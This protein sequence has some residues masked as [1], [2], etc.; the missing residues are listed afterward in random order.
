MT[1]RNSS[2][3]ICQL[4]LSHPKNIRERFFSAMLVE[5]DNGRKTLIT[6]HLAAAWVFEYKTDPAEDAVH[7]LLQGI[8]DDKAYLKQLGIKGLYSVDYTTGEDVFSTWDEYEARLKAKI[9]AEE[10]GEQ[11]FPDGSE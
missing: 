6:V 9:A 7:A 11:Y 5:T 2:Q 3:G 8:E 1:Q 10:R 4:T